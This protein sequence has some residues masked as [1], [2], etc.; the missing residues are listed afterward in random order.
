MTAVRADAG[1]QGPTVVLRGFRHARAPRPPAGPAVAARPVAPVAA[2]APTGLG[3][4]PPTAYPAIPVPAS[5]ALVPAGLTTRLSGIFPVEVPASS[6]FPL[7]D[8]ALARGR[9]VLACEPETRGGHAAP[10]RRLP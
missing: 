5:A 8:R 7:L 10:G 1:G 6:G 3:Y 4:P 2:S 9:W